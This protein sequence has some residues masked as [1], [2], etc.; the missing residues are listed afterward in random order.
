VVNHVYDPS[1]RRLINHA[2]HHYEGQ[3]SAFLPYH[4]VD[5]A[6]SP[7]YDALRTSSGR[8]SLVRHATVVKHEGVHVVLSLPTLV[9]SEL[10]APELLSSEIKALGPWP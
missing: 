4:E 6:A 5:S 2:M 10:F 8:A 9:G 1:Y 3:C 7:V